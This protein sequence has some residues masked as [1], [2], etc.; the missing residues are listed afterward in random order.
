MEAGEIFGE[1]VRFGVGPGHEERGGLFPFKFEEPEAFF[2]RVAAEEGGFL[3]K[4][5]EVSEHM[6]SR[7]LTPAS[8]RTFIDESEAVRDEAPPVNLFHHAGAEGE[9]EVTKK[10]VAV[11]FFGDSERAA[12][13]AGALVG[14][15]DGG[16]DAGVFEG[17]VRF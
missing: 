6:E 16:I 13:P 11:S 12:F 2:L 3:P 5:E 10:I 4:L 14:G 7:P 17:P 8:R 1:G 9:G 15:V